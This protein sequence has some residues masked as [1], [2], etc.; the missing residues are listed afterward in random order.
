VPAHRVQDG[1]LAPLFLPWP[2]EHVSVAVTRPAPAAG[3][4]TA[5]DAA[6]LDVTP[7]VRLQNATLAL[8]V[9]SSRGASEAVRL[10]SG[11]RVQSLTVDGAERP[12][13]LSG[14]SVGFSLEPG[15]HRVALQW[16][17]PIE[18]ATAMQVPSVGL[19]R[20]SANAHVSVHLPE[21]RWLLWT[22]GPAWGPAVLF[23]GYLAFVL[24]VAALLGRVGRTPL[25]TRHFVLLGLGLTQVPAPA[26]LCVVG[27]FFAMAYR[28][29][30]P[31]QGRFT[32]NVIQLGLA[33][34]TWSALGC[35]YFAVHA[36][37]LMQPD[38]QVA[39][40]GSAAN[41]LHWF[42][43]RGA[44]AVLPTP[45][46]WSAPIWVWRVLMLLWS[47]WLAAS[48]VRWLPWAFACFR[49]DGLWKKGPAR[50]R[51]LWKPPAPPAP[52]PSPAPP[53]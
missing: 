33:F 34:W 44:G 27:W 22:S 29:R 25:G 6:D 10:P 46:V 11:A 14:D 20:P 21:D 23:W 28:G 13:R 32:H 40:A 36:G 15:A 51:K 1:A 35:L 43:D 18:L 31:E 38:M 26:A 47:L 45:T 19:T 53:G 3:A 17:Q 50:E 12:M 39:G 9:R 5:I 2:G 30:M 4:A 8:D 42:A 37:L 52:P 41:A 48:V 24:L 16:Q 7:G 49:H